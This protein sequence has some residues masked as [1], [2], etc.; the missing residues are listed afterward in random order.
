MRF[1]LLLSM[2]SGSKTLP[3]PTLLMSVICAVS[4]L[5][6]LRPLK[7]YFFYK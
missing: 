2:I 6:I 4:F 3:L 1:T 7:L 5:N